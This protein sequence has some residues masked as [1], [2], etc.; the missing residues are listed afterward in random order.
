M[1]TLGRFYAMGEWLTVVTRTYGNNRTA[2]ELL[3]KDGASF[4]VLSVNLPDLPVPS[5]DHF[6]AKT[7]SENESLR[8]PALVSGLFVD[9]GK[10]AQ[11]GWVT[12]ELW[13]I[14]GAKP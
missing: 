1:I 12:A 9:T 4:A 3:D 10:R 11:S 6:W 2:I 8:E 13:K 14:T 5:G 7:W